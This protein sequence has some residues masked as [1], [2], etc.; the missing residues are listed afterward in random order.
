MS[1]DPLGDELQFIRADTLAVVGALLVSLKDVIGAVGVGA[2]GTLC[3]EGLLTEVA[4][5]HG[6]DLGDLLEDLVT[7][8]LNGG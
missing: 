6:V 4:A 8:L 1:Q 2:G 3:F 5:D 7:L